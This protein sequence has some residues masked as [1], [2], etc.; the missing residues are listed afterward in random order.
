MRCCSW[1]TI[2][3][4]RGA[5]LAF[6]CVALKNAAL[7]GKVLCEGAGCIDPT[8]LSSSRYVTGTCCCVMSLPHVQ[9]AGGR[10]L[11]PCGNPRSKLESEGAAA[12]QGRRNSARPTFESVS[13]AKTSPGPFMPPA[14]GTDTPVTFGCERPLFSV[15]RN[16][17]LLLSWFYPARGMFTVPA[18]LQ[19]ARNVP[20]LTFQCSLFMDSLSRFVVSP[21]NTMVMLTALQCC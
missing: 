21:P 15:H 12:G 14:V 20:S 3:L 6:L 19:K 9:Q 11:V 18:C 4:G 17:L 7:L 8:N 2:A 1:Q 13:A 5:L 16:Q 10:R